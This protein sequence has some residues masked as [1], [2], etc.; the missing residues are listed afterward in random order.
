MNQEQSALLQQSEIQ[1]ELHQEQP[2]AEKNSLSNSLSPARTEQSHEQPFLALGLRPELVRA[3]QELG[4]TTPTLIQ[5]KSIPAIKAGKDLIGMSKTGSGKTAAFGL[6]ILE[7]IKPRAGLQALVIAP[8]RE[9]AVQI[10]QELRKFGKYLPFRLATVYGGVSLAPQMEQIAQAD[11]VVG[12]PGRLKDHL[13]RRTMDVSRLNCVVLDEADK[14]VEMGFIEDIEYLLS[15]MPKSRQLLLFGATISK[16]IDYLTQRYM[17]A[18]VTAEAEAQVQEEYLE[19]F[20][21]NVPH[22]EKFSLLVHLLKKE[23]IQRAILFC[24]SRST[25]E[26][27]SRNLRQQGIDNEMMHGKLSQ[28]RRLRVIQQFHQGK[29]PILVASAVAARGLDIKDVSHILNY[30]LAADPQEYIHRI[31]RTAR[32]G[33]SGKAITLLSQ[34]DYQ[35]FSDIL[36]RYRV[37]VQE[38][39]LEAFQRLRFDARRISSDRGSSPGYHGSGD[40]NVRERSRR[41]DRPGR[42]PSSR[43]EQSRS[44]RPPRWGNSWRR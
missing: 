14:M 30:D 15:Y 40:R 18:P 37:N 43:R 27:V 9:L 17:H 19:Q 32:A 26:L 44:Y 35:A 23:P 38:L 6:P 41:F 39:P 24:S 10:G 29:T 1:R 42:F 2:L 31:G 8:T 13:D 5:E 36:S 21:Y 22:H 7:K 11:I 33:E 25:V 28:N 34:K 16:E 4:I 3:L 20:Y 12:T